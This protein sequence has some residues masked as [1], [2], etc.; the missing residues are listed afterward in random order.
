MFFQVQ[1]LSLNKLDQNN[2][3]LTKLDFGGVNRWPINKLVEE[4][5]EIMVEERMKNE[6][7]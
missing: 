2:E 5:K 3:I 7:M 6:D 4:N 1:I